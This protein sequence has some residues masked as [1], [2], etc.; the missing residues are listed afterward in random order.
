MGKRLVQ[1]QLLQAMEDDY[2]VGF[3]RFGRMKKAIMSDEEVVQSNDIMGS[4][5][6]TW[7]WVGG[8]RTVAEES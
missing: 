3:T 2:L 8:A 7:G 4:H 5:N 6:G 1:T